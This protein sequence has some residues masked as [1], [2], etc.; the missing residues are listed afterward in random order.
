M[1]EIGIDQFL[2]ILREEFERLMKEWDHGDKIMTDFDKA[3]IKALMRY[4]K[5]K[6]IALE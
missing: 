5:E 1:S 3:S 6:G 2:D 4:A